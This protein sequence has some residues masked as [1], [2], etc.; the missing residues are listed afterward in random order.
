MSHCSYTR[1]MSGTEFI[2]RTALCTEGGSSLHQNIH[3]G[4]NYLEVA[5]SSLHLYHHIRLVKTKD[6][7]ERRR[8]GK[9]AT[10]R[11]SY[12]GGSGQD[13]TTDVK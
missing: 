13:V 3:E 4:V 12:V 11:E 6:K 5:G 9:E 8:K 7:G 10:W 2:L 1:G